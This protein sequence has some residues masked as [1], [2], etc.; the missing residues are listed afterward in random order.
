MLSIAMLPQM[1]RLL[2]VDDD[3]GMV[4]AC[5]AVARRAGFAV[6]TAATGQAAMDVCAAGDVDVAIVDVLMPGMGGIEVLRRIRAAQPGCVV[7]IMTGLGDV[8]GAVEAMRLGAHD[9]W[10]KPVSVQTMLDRLQR[11]AIGA[12]APGLMADTDANDERVDGLDG[13]SPA[14][15]ALFRQLR[16]TAPYAR[17][18]LITGETGT[19]KEVVARALH[20]LGPRAACPFVSLNCSALVE[21]LTETQLF[22]YVR[23]AFTGAA[24]STQGL[25]EAAHRGV[26]FL[27]EVG[28]LPLVAQAKLLRVLD[29]GEVL[30]VGATEARRVDVVVIAATHRDLL[31][32]VANG[33]FRE[34]LFY[35]LN[36]AA[37][38]LPPLRDRRED[39]PIL[40]ETFV[41]QI[42]ARV[43]RTI[44]RIHPQAME[45]LANAE[46]PGNIRELLNVIER[47]CLA[48]DGREISV[49]VIN[50]CLERAVRSTAPAVRE[51]GRAQ[52]RR[53]PTVTREQI[54]AALAD[55]RGSRT[56]AADRLAVSRRALYRLMKRHHLP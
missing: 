8:A 13:R 55:T 54:L 21:G 33:R 56:L 7:I 30:R 43:G 11:L 18:V 44:D 3:S 49:A 1:A 26:L 40:A 42:A 45:L 37:I 53:A 36:V 22:G 34:D 5:A 20:L 15:R 38:R 24:H 35:R 41:R 23:G 50:Q 39:I 16:R 52:G 10:V 31:Y 51:G 47:A 46:W 4:A 32:E 19:G 2:V 9:Y 12:R 17:T 28:E 14:M 29:A 48:A 6:S 25:F 27:D